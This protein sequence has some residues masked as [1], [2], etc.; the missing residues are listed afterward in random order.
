MRAEGTLIAFRHCIG[1]LN[2]GTNGGNMNLKLKIG[3][4]SL[5]AFLAAGCEPPTVNT[6][7]NVNTSLDNKT[8][9]NASNA[10]SNASNMNASAAISEV[11]EPEKYQAK[12]T[13]SLQAENTA[14]QNSALPNIAAVVARN[15]E[16]RR[17]E[18]T[19]PNGQ[20]AVYLETG[21]KNLVVLPGRNQYAELNEQSTGLNVRSLMMPEQIVRQMQNMQGVKRVGEE[22]VN[23][24][25]AVKYVYESVTDTKSQAGN[26]ETESYFLVDKETGLPLRSE[27]VSES[28][29]GSVQGFKGI[30][31]ITEMSD[32]TTEVPD[33]L[34]AEPT[35]LQK[36]DEAQIR[37]QVETVFAVVMN[38]LTQALKTAQT[39]QPAQP[40]A[41]SNANAANAR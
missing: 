32:I 12:I 27:T 5:L 3:T 2:F 10:D 40:A 13:L 16:K 17:M 28:Q 31:I 9:V 35:D 41:N 23:G 15:G 30:R 38:V 26:V 7:V 18:F 8:N 20:K 6:N 14:G 25:A 39:A 34:F 37:G 36:V 22:T 4:V 29:G 33:E 21:G 24:R 11:K 1:V 19:L